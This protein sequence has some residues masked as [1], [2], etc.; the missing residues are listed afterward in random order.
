MK[1]KWCGCRLLLE[2][3]REREMCVDCICKKEDA[4]N[5]NE[6]NRYREMFP[7]PPWDD[8]P[9]TAE[10][11]ERLGYKKNEPNSNDHTH[12]YTMWK[13]KEYGEAY[14]EIVLLAPN[15]RV[16]QDERERYPHTTLSAGC[17]GPMTAGQLACLIAARRNN[18]KH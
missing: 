2:F 6:L 8:S 16:P 3:E 12:L 17:R 11:C 10:V 13:N 14:T 18:E 7:I 1:C 15:T 9:I 5:L 4:E